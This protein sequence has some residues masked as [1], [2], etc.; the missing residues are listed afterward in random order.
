M[1]IDTSTVRRLDFPV[2]L[3]PGY[4]DHGQLVAGCWVPALPVCAERTRS[5]LRGERDG[6]WLLRSAQTVFECTP[7]APQAVSLTARQKRERGREG[8]TD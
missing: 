6:H 4:Y 3:R 8:E 1:T 2:S 7:L 5:R